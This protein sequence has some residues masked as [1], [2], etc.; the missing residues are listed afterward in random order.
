MR[1][2]GCEPDDSALRPIRLYISSLSTYASSFI[3]G[4]V[5]SVCARGQI[6]AGFLFVFVLF[7][8][9]TEPRQPSAVFILACKTLIMNKPFTSAA[10]FTSPT[11]IKLTINFFFFPFLLS[12]LSQLR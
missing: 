4:Y 5:L 7:F 6:S 1:A 8:L 10:V 11:A 2:M 12:S 3:F 9:S